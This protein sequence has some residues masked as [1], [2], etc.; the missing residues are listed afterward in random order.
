MQ[1]LAATLPPGRYLRLAGEKHVPL[2]LPEEVMVD[3]V[4]VYA[5]RGMSMP[6]ALVSALANPAVVLLHSGEAA[7]HFAA[8]SARLG[9]ER[10]AHRAR[11]PR[12]ANRAAGRF[13]LATY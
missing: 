10:G 6:P 4:V 13:G 5:A 7:L 2:A 12:T 1:P 9:V 8:E 3:D 11:L